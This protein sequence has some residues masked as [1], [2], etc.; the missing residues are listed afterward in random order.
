MAYTT[1]SAPMWLSD[2]SMQILNGPHWI[3]NNYV[4][5]ARVLDKDRDAWRNQ[6]SQE[7]LLRAALRNLLKDRF[8]FAFHARTV[9][10]T[11]YDL[12]AT[13]RS[14]TK[15][16]DTSAGA[17]L[18]KGL[19]LANGAVRVDGHYSDGSSVEH[20]YNETMDD[21]AYQLSIAT[22][23][24]VQN[25]TGLTGRYNFAL[26]Y[27]HLSHEIDELPNN[28]SIGDLGLKIKR[29]K[30]PGITLVID[31]IEEPSQN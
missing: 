5:D 15:L 8:K 28:W 23:R 30:R 21:L 20:Y 31:H 11:G 7:E 4:I 16:Q 10:T 29:V 13:K 2:G 26:V 17:A 1:E 3:W 22:R 19:V 25:K 14:G 12:V 18:P 27:R 24:F 6:S 9:D